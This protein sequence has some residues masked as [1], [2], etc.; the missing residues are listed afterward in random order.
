MTKER[1]THLCQLVIDPR[2]PSAII[3]AQADKIEFLE[4]IIAGNGV[5]LNTLQEAIKPWGSGGIITGTVLAWIAAK[6]PAIAKAIVNGK[7]AVDRA[8]N[9]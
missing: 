7:A 1:P 9:P 4:G 3:Q 2:D 6:D 8:L 5:L